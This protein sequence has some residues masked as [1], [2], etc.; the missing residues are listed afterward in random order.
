MK[1]IKV[2]PTIYNIKELY[3]EA[4]TTEQRELL[5]YMVKTGRMDNMT[6]GG[7]FHMLGELNNVPKKETYAFSWDDD[8][9][10]TEIISVAEAA[11]ARV[12]KKFGISK[13]E[14]RRINKNIKNLLDD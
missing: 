11:R 3:Q 9:V 1:T 2:M 12:F 5:G 6:L 7:A 8:D 14:I 13:R 4:I 10:A